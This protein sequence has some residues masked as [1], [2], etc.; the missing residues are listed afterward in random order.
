MSES[1][2]PGGGA[3][4]PKPRRRKG[5]KGTLPS[6]TPRRTVTQDRKIG[7]RLPVSGSRE[8]RE[9]IARLDGGGAA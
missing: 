8:A 6:A 1:Y 2:D 3:S 4:G 5:M 7:S 9:R